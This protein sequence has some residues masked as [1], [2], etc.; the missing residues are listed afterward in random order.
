[1]TDVPHSDALVFFGATG[2]LAYKQVFPALYDMT[3]NGELKIPVIGVAYSQWTLEDLHKR[4]RDSIKAHGGI[5]DEAAQFLHQH[6]AQADGALGN[7]ANEEYLTG[8]RESL[9]PFTH[10]LST[11]SRRSSGP[12]RNPPGSCPAAS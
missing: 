3:K 12:P 1:M 5:D 8:W 9:H 7:L 10:R 4:A 6:M 2:D 11:G